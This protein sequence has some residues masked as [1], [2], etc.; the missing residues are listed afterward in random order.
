MSIFCSIGTVGAG[1]VK[2]V[3]RL[4]VVG[5]VWILGDDGAVLEVLLTM[6]EPKVKVLTAL[7]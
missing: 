7:H 5:E 1:S 6:F 2:F 3:E 4:A